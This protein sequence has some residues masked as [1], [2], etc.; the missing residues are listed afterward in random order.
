MI[1][2][3]D[4][5]HLS[6][7][8]KWNARIGGQYSVDVGVGTLS[9]RS[10]LSY[11]SRIYFFALDRVNPF[12]REVSSRPD[13]DLSARIS[14][15]DIEVGN[16]K[17]DVGLWGANLTNQ[18]NLDFGIDFGGLGFGAGSYKKPRTVGGDVKL[19]F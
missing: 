1:N 6:Q 7:T 15:S 18:R 4:E 3:G 19:S 17:I 5:A 14:L 16:A 10:D 9:L 13:Y 11:R 8:P 2:V 12:N